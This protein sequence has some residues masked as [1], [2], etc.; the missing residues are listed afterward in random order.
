MAEKKDEPSD[1]YCMGYHARMRGEKEMPGCGPW[2][3]NREHLEYRDGFC[4]ACAELGD[5][6]SGE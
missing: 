1:F 6:E 4:R 5:E 3:N 2:R